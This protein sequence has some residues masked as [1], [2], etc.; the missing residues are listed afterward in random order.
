MQGKERRD[1][2]WAPPKERPPLLVAS[3]NAPQEYG[4]WQWAGDA[5]RARGRLGAEAFRLQ[6]N[7]TLQCPAG[8]ILWFSELRQENAFTQRAVYMAS[9]DDCQECN[10]REQCLGRGAR[11]NRARRVSAVRRLLPTH[12]SLEPQMGVLAATRWV[13]GAGRSLRRTWIVHWRRQY[14]EVLPLAE[15]PKSVSPPSRLPRAIRSHRR[16][17]WH[18]RL[19]RNAWWGPPHVR[20]SVAGVPAFLASSER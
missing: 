3:E 8:A 10:L 11:G 17:S 14:V 20:V 6:E 2:E 7:G 18:D 1:I 4:P 5:G 16:W 9:L 12:S 15:I 13:D 19:A